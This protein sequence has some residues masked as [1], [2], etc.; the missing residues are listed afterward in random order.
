MTKQDRLTKLSK[1]IDDLGGARCEEIELVHELESMAER[2]KQLSDR[3]IRG[4]RDDVVRV[5]DK[6]RH[7][8][9]RLTEVRVEI[10]ELTTEMERIKAELEYGDE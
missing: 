6:R 5:I 9:E 7:T 2:I 4:D 10:Q 8:R 3:V 1:T